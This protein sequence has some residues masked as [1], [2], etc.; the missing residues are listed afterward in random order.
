MEQLKRMIIRA[1]NWLG[2]HIMALSCYQRLRQAYPNSELTLLCPEGLDGI[3]PPGVFNRVWPFKK[4]ELQE[5]LGRQSWVQQ[6]ESERFDMSVSLPASWSSALLFYRA[7]IPFRIGFSQSG[8]GWLQ[9]KS[10]KWQGMQSGKHK[11]VLYQELVELVLN[12]DKTHSSIP[13]RLSQKTSGKKFWV[14]APGAALPLREW[15]YFPELLH[16]ISQR[17]PDRTF[18]VVGTQIE[19]AWKSRLQRW[20]LP[21]VEDW[22]GKTSLGNLQQMTQ[23]AELV[24]ANDSGVAHVAATLGQARTVVIFGPGNPQYIAPIGPGVVPVVPA[25]SVT[26]SPCE[27]S[28]CRA[29]LGYQ[30]CLKEIS[31]DQVLQKIETALLL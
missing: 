9:H 22:V 24:I 14:I 1:P 30:R 27:K 17:Y 21:R 31:L 25:A 3:V 15:P 18:R 7:R 11:A 4:A 23:E 26:C 8:S 19:A 20:G 12:S 28:F 13:A 6:I 29:P 10:L 5:P 2:D 16:E